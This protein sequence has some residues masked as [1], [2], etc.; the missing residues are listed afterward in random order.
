M[1][2]KTVPGKLFQ[3]SV[4]ES[5]PWRAIQASPDVEPTHLSGGLLEMAPPPDGSRTG[6]TLSVMS[7][8]KEIKYSNTRG[9]HLGEFRSTTKVVSKL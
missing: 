7:K 2:Y 3:L 9:E 6:G 8:G 4:I 5:A 1:I